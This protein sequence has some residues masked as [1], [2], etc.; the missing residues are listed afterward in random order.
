MIIYHGRRKPM[1]DN[2]GKVVKKYPPTFTIGFEWDENSKYMVI[3][4]A[5]ANTKHEP[6]DRKSG[7]LTVETRIE[8]LVGKLEHEEDYVV[9]DSAEYT[10]PRY[11]VRD[12]FYI[13]YK[14]F[15]Y[16]FNKA[17]KYYD[18]NEKEIS[19]FLLYYPTSENKIYGK[20]IENFKRG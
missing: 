15:D 5:A 4:W 1:F 19:K 2:I 3:G 17:L 9:H 16:Y 12:C 6:Y 13:M 7:R 10:E 14:N 8:R 11:M 18:I 20:I